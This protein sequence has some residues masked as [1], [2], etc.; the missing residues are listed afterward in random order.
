MVSEGPGKRVENGAETY[1]IIDLETS[2]IISLTLHYMKGNPEIRQRSWLVPCQ[3][4]IELAPKTW[5]HFLSLICYSLHHR[6][7]L[8]PLMERKKYPS[9]ISIL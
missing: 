2:E 4:M 8:Q 5:H 9:N 7:S 3:L 1:K 6:M